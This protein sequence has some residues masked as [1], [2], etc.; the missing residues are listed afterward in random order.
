MSELS[1]WL[2][3]CSVSY[4]SFIFALLKE[5]G[6]LSKSVLLKKAR[7]FYRG[8]ACIRSPDQIPLVLDTLEEV[9]II[10]SRRYKAGSELFYRINWE[11]VHPVTKQIIEESWK[12][13]KPYIPG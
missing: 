9:G 6:E 3:E 8:E 4:V 13:L 2:V 12:M 7:K 10:I 5:Y 1:F 11:A